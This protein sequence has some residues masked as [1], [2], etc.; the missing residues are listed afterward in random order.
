MRSAAIAVSC[1][2]VHLK[3]I[4]MMAAMHKEQPLSQAPWELDDVLHIVKT[5]DGHL[6]WEFWQVA[7]L[8]ADGDADQMLGL[9][10]DDL[11][12]LRN[13][14]H[15]LVVNLKYRVEDFRERQAAKRPTKVELQRV[16][17]PRR[18]APAGAR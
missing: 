4:V 11:V 10:S 12:R 3:P 6:C 15:N 16:T 8:S 7:Q 2:P 5:I 1:A 13:E 18:Q 17:H 14:A 9:M